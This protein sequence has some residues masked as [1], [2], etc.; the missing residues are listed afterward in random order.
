MN[1]LSHAVVPVP[2]LRVLVLAQD[3]AMGRKLRDLACAYGHRAVQ[4]AGDADVALCADGATIPAGIPAVICGAR[5]RAVAGWLPADA[6][7][8]Q[9]DA[10]LRA[11]AAGL[12]V[13]SPAILRDG[14]EALRETDPASALTPREAQVLACL[15]QGLS[16]KAIA[17]RLDISPHTVK[18]HLESL[19]RKLGVAT[20]TEAVAAALEHAR[21]ATAEF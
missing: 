20:R 3:P 15:A 4:R 18:F 11:V 7:A 12:V 6:N 2:S 1:A 5:S 14:F 17:R 10:A 8:I 21:I 13:R 9:L 19:F 16:N